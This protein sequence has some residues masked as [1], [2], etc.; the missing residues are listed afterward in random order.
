MVVSKSSNTTSKNG[1][2]MINKTFVIS[3]PKLE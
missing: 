3:K 1:Y 2:E